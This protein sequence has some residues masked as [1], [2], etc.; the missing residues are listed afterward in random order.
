MANTVNLRQARKEKVRA[1][2]RTAADANALK[3]GQSKSDK[4]RQLAEMKIALDRHAAHKRD[5][6]A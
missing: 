3:F 2:K 5:T 6:D 1:Q 4:Q